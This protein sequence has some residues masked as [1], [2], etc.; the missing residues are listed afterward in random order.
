MFP[1][2]TVS[3]DNFRSGVLAA[4]RPVIVLF[5]TQ[6]CAAS[7]ALATLLAA[8][9]VEHSG[10]V[11]AVWLDLAES[12]DVAERYSVAATPTLLVFS[13][14]DLRTRIV[15][16]VPHGLLLL[17]LTQV[18]QGTL[19]PDPYWSPRETLVEDTLILPLL[20][21]AGLHYQ[22]Q[23]SCPLAPDDPRVRGRIDLLVFRDTQ[24]P[25]ATLIESKRR[26][27]TAHDLRRATIQALGYAQALDLATFAVA[28]P[29][30]LWLFRRDGPRV[31]PLGTLTSLTITQQ[32]EQAV[33][34]LH[35]LI[36]GE[37]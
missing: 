21:A 29:A 23:V 12:Y 22:R 19:P 11:G 36:P 3:D 18:G 24:A 35:R 27:L 20:T 2:N 13:H 5:G 1:L 15:G 8:L 7:Q 10:A 28:A 25:P 37:H 32:P 17:L 34:V 26:L 6:D 30:G 33:A 9:L 14:G 16:F 31:A 4:T